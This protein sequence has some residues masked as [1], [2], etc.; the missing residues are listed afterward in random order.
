MPA[1]DFSNSKPKLREPVRGMDRGHEI[2]SM[3]PPS[4]G[5]IHVG[6]ILNILENFTLKKLEPNSADFI[7]LVTAAMQLAFDVHH[8]LNKPSLSSPRAGL[9]IVVMKVVT[10]KVG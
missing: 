3:P 8:F 6:Q 9:G 1:R 5:G 4:S 2:I 10:L 7:H